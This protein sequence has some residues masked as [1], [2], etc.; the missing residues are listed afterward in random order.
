M[1]VHHLMGINRVMGINHAVPVIAR[2][3]ENTI[4]LRQQHQNKNFRPN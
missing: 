1:G 2:S 4:P 3:A